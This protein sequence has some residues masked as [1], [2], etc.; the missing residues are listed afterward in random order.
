[1][2]DVME[3]LKKLSNDLKDKIDI[4]Y[5]NLEE[6]RSCPLFREDDIEINPRIDSQGDVFF[7]G[8]FYGKENVIGNIYKNSLKE[9]INSQELST[10]KEIIKQR[11]NNKK[12]EVCVFKKICSCGCPAISFMNTNNILDINTQCKMIKFFIKNEFKQKKDFK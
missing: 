12:C 4:S 5:N 9:I 1:M 2:I 11:K 6:Q 8:Y 3:N 7:C 10:F